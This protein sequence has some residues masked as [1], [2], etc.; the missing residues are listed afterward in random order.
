MQSEKISPAIVITGASG[1]GKSLSL[2]LLKQA[3]PNI[4]IFPKH[5]TRSRR[6]DENEAV[7]YHF[8]SDESVQK[9]I[10]E[11]KFIHLK[12]SD[13]DHHLYGIS[14]EVFQKYLE[15]DKI[16]C[17]TAHG[18]EEANEVKKELTNLRITTFIIYI[19]TPEDRRVEQLVKSDQKEKL[20]LRYHADIGFKQVAFHSMFDGCDFVILNDIAIDTLKT[21]IE[22]VGK[23]I[24][25]LTKENKPKKILNGDLLRI[26]NDISEISIDTDN[27]M[28]MSNDKSIS[29]ITYSTLA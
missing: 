19:Y 3:C 27:S 25:Q 18:I 26:Q 22:V 2:E 12:K 14:R 20:A 11:D 17:F 29:Q 4:S 6:P 10:A 15:E 8:I 23:W 28:C 21:R 13:Y 1:S 5:T 9:M 16:P 24:C 7:H